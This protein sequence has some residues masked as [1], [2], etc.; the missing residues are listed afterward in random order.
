[1]YDIVLSCKP[2]YVAE[3]LFI[4]QSVLQYIKSQSPKQICDKPEKN[5]KLTEK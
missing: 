5:R 1:M 3:L 4:L 2:Q